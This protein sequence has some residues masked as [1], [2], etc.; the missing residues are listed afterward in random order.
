M[1]KTRKVISNESAA[2]KAD[3]KPRARPTLTVLAILAVFAMLYLARFVIV[4]V[5][6][7]LIL[8]FVFT[9]P[10]RRLRSAGIP[11][12]A[13]AAAVLAFFLA[14]LAACAWYLSGPALSWIDRA[15]QVLERVE[16]Y[17]ATV[18]APMERVEKATSQAKS[19][20]SGSDS[21]QPPVPSSRVGFHDTL[22]PVVQAAATLTLLYLL[23]AS[24][25]LL[26]RKVIA[27]APTLTGKK[28]SLQVVREIEDAISG[29]LG[30]L[31]LI[32]TGFG[33]L[34][35]VGLFLI[36]MPAPALWGLVAGLFNFIPYLGPVATAFI[37]TLVGAASFADIR[38]ALIVPVVFW[39]VTSVEG[40]ILRP[41]LLGW[42]L[43]LNPVVS[44][45]ALL[46]FGWMW[47]PPGLLLAV[48]V[49]AVLKI[50]ADRVDSLARLAQIL[51]R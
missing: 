2:D 34:V 21:A 37:L 8:K 25:D 6:A 30:V 36:G 49:L 41:Y 22:R 17:L 43:S 28:N 5:V 45:V 14:A 11:E 50:I 46:V 9:K 20:I 44:F 42:R 35:G 51:D 3:P 7:A 16:Q 40:S 24:G 10:V 27:M 31:A 19:A 23:L 32:N 13:G 48:P 29:Y 38:I 39:V 12:P 1:L 15:P 4:P 47:G 33:T 26:H 18:R